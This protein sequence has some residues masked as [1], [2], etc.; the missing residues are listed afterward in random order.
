MFILTII[1]IFL[2]IAY[3]GYLVYEYAQKDVPVYVKLLTFISWT[4]S[5]GIVF[6][7]PHDIYYVNIYNPISDCTTSL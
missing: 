2:L 5:F 1:E 7:L 4:M 6:I 3:V